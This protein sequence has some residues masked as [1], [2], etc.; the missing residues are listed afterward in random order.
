MKFAIDWKKSWI[1]LL[2]SF[3]HP[4]FIVGALMYLGSIEYVLY[5]LGDQ[6]LA[7]AL[8]I[9]GLGIILCLSYQRE[10]KTINANRYKKVK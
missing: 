4:L 8:S 3:S 2:Y 5:G 7:V 10:Y 1:N 9:F 6:R